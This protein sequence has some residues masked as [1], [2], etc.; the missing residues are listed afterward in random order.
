MRPARETNG[1]DTAA[2]LALLY[3]QLE[4]NAA[5]FGMSE[6]ELEMIKKECKIAFQHKKLLDKIAQRRKML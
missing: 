3:K 2:E 6:A 5:A 1:S 4:T